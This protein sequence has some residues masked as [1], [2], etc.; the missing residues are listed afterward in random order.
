MTGNFYGTD[1][2]NLHARKD[3]IIFSPQNVHR[4]LKKEAGDDRH[5]FNR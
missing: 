4:F 1:G 5:V 3:D 2:A